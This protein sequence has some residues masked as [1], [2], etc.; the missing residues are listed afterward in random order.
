MRGAE[1]G[2]LRDVEVMRPA[3]VAG[4]DGALLSGVFFVFV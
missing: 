3:T 1:A 2:A 4:L